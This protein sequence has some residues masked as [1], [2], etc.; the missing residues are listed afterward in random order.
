MRETLAQLAEGRREWVALAP[1]GG[2]AP[3][4][5]RPVAL[6]SGSFN[7]LHEGH[8]GVARAA[9]QRLEKSVDFEL[10]L[11]NVDK[12][13]LPVEEV[14]R[15]AEQF[16]GVG[17]LVVTHV[18]TFPQKARLFPGCAF[19]IGYDTAVR[20]V[21]PR[22]YGGEAAMFRKLH[23]MLTAGTRFVVAGRLVDDQFL[24]LADVDVPG[25]FGELFIELSEEEFRE[26]LSSTALRNQL[27]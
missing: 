26:D 8:L 22:Y 13:P 25:E 17:I 14:A 21:A 6:L 9:S 11:V 1:S 16:R 3:D 27:Y 24:T 10:S 2:A 19:V 5:W 4:D 7:P 23:A 18:P 20:V 15:R 12:P